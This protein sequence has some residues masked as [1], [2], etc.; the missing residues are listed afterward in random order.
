MKKWNIIVDVEN[1]TNCQNCT[2]AVMDEYVGNAFPHYSAPHPPHG[3]HWVEIKKRERGSGS[4]LDVAYLNV[5]CN[6]CDKAPCVRAAKDGAIYKRE[7]GIV[8]I[9]PD[10]AKGQKQLVKACPYGH[11]WWNDEHQVPQ[12][13]SLDAHLLDAG[14]PEPRITQVCASG[15]L[16]AVKLEDNEMRQKAQE[17]GLERLRPELKTEGRVWYKNLHLFMKE[18]L[19]GSVATYI[20]GLD[21]CC[22]AAQ[23]EL[24]KEGKCLQRT[25]TD[26]F[27]DFKFQELESNSGKYVVR[28]KWNGIEKEIAV[29]LE[30]AS[31]NIGDIRLDNPEAE[32][33]HK[34]AS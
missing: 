14:W 29:N 31:I 2:M 13:Y 11:I 17:Q 22:E 25:V 28:I 32:A 3:H 12:K 6:Q 33:G 16:Y 15:C 10:K 1:C 8:M 9:D 20:N 18:H 27:G 24:Y 4:L 21:E 26:F 5:M 30:A 23:V 19:A 34:S 7:D